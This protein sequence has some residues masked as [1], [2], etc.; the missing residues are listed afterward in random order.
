M[1][2]PPLA[3]APDPTRVTFQ[4]DRGLMTRLQTSQI[5]HQELWPK[6]SALYNTGNPEVLHKYQV[7][8]C[9]YVKRHDENLEAKWRGPFLLLL[10]TSTSVKVDGVSLGLCHTNTYT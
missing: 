1:G 7:G 8:D 10:N 6:L 3:L 9:V 5:S 4:D 2:P